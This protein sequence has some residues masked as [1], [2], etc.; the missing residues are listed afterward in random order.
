MALKTTSLSHLVQKLTKH[1]ST[2]FLNMKY[3][4]L[5]ILSVCL[6]S[7]ESVMMSFFKRLFCTNVI[8]NIFMSAYNELREGL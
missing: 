3:M 2:K 1:S 5:K 8:Q 7:I 6:R 4:S